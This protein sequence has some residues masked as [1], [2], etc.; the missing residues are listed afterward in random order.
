V[1]KQGPPQKLQNIPRQNLIP[2]QNIQNPH[3]SYYSGYSSTGNQ[4]IS[5]N[6]S[7]FQTPKK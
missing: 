2:P 1:I 3:Q 6:A 4:I 5:N 7:Q